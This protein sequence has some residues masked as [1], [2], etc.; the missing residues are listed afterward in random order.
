MPC[1]ALF[2]GCCV[3]CFRAANRKTRWRTSCWAG[4]LQ[5]TVGEVGSGAGAVQSCPQLYAHGQLS[6]LSVALLQPRQHFCTEDKWNMLNK[7]PKFQA[8]CLY[9]WEGRK[10]SHAARSLFLIYK[11][12][13]IFTVLLSCHFIFTAGIKFFYISFLCFHCTL[14]LTG[15]IPLSPSASLQFIFLILF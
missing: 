13:Y 5:S 6:S 8:L 4:T 2:D 9:N 14:N 10:V 1:I 15:Y 11:L 3:Q 12:T 7:K